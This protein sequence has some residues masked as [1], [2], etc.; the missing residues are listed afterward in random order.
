MQSW[1]LNSHYSF[2]LSQN[3]SEIILKCWFGAQEAFHI[4]I[5]NIVKHL[6]SLFVCETVN[7]FSHYFFLWIQS[8]KVKNKN[9]T[10]NF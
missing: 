7:I 3:P 5:I 8:K 1:I 4:S 9:T 10:Q 6:L 2:L